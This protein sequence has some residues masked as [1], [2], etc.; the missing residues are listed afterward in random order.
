MASLFSVI[1]SVER[2]ARRA[3]TCSLSAFFS[4]ACLSGTALI[5]EALDEILDKSAVRVV[6]N[7]ARV[8]S[9]CQECHMKCVSQKFLIWSLSV[10]GL[11]T[12]LY[13]T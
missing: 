8:E 7:Q 10:G 1:S 5:P 6:A 11:V 9:M 3:L 12:S 4:I 2:V 13:G